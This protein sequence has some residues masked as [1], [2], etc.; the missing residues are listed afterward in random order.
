MDMKQVKTIEIDDQVFAE[1]SQRA[2][3][4]HVTPNDVLRRILNLSMPAVPR[5]A[6]TGVATPAPAASTLVEF[7][8]SDR[9]Q[10]HRQA[11]D[12]FLA[13]LGWLHGAHRIQFVDVVLGFR[14]GKRLYF[15][16]SQEEIEESGRGITARPIPESQIWVLT[17]LDNK[18]KRII[19]EDVLQELS[20]SRNDINLAVA[21]LPDSDIRRRHAKIFAALKA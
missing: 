11:V 10:R 14:R 21:E 1:L 3:G 17:T 4:F 16:K 18:S 12:R 13:I 2:T 15:A 19:I 5:A 9:F 20:Y 6:R 7:I 8:R